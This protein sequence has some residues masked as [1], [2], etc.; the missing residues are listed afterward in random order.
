MLDQVE[1][2]GLA[3]VDVVEDDHHRLVDSVRLQQ[4]AKRPR[5]LVGGAGGGLVAEDRPECGIDAVSSAEKLLHDLGDRPVANPFAVGEA[6]AAHDGGVLERA[7]ELGHEARLPDARGAE[8]G[9]E[10]AGA[11]ADDIRQRVLEQVPLAP[12]AD[13]RCAAASRRRPDLTAT[14]R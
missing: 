8:H 1:K 7:Q 5:D 14:R 10:L 9:E 13:H 3:P 6:A 12:A 11:L 2:G 4:L